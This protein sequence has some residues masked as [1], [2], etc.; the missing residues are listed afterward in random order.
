MIDFNYYNP[1]EIIF[2]QGRHQ[3]VGE[4]IKARGGRRVLFHYGGGSIKR[5]GLYEDVCR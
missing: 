4:Q 2:G 5:S 3:E 1:T